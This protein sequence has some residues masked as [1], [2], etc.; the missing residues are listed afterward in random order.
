[1]SK[2]NCDYCGSNNVE[3][4]GTPFLADVPAKMCEI[5]WNTTKDEYAASEDVYI[6]EFIEETLIEENNM[7]DKPVTFSEFLYKCISSNE[8]VYYS[9]REECGGC[10]I[11]GNEWNTDEAKK[12]YVTRVYVNK[13]GQLQIIVFP[14]AEFID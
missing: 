7:S 4:K 14:I 1:M 11:K 12:Y 3:V 6:G 10:V 2:G 5:C 13:N 9:E 8:M